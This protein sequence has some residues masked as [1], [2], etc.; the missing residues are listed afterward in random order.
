MANL[1]IA[2]RTAHFASCELQLDQSVS[3]YLWIN[4]SFE[5]RI[6][7]VY[8][9]RQCK[10]KRGNIIYFYIF[11]N[12]LWLNSRCTS[13]SNCEFT[14]INWN[15]L[16]EYSSIQNRD[17]IL[18]ELFPGILQNGCS[19]NFGQFSGKY[20]FK[21]LQFFIPHFIKIVHQ[22]KCFPENIPKFEEEL[23]L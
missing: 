1:W 22:H 16:V 15:K 4:Q 19:Q 13:E 11:N 5:L 23:F 9:L 21:K 6:V 3:C 2:S 18:N 12:N 8:T 10:S 20:F 7:P 17:Q 14:V